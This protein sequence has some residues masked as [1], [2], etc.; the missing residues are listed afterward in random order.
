MTIVWIV[1]R[2]QPDRPR[3]AL[4]LVRLG[5]GLRL[6]LAALL[7]GLALQADIGAGLLAL[8]GLSVARWLLVGWIGLR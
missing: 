3:R 1:G 6:V 4:M 2:M 7:L 8:A 5:F